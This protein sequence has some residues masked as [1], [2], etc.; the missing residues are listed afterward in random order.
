VGVREWAFGANGAIRVPIS[1]PFT[2][3]NGEALMRAACAGQGIVYSPRFMTAGAIADGRLVELDVGVPLLDLGAIYAIT[4]P[5]RRPAAR[6]RAHASQSPTGTDRR[7]R[8]SAPLA[9]A[10]RAARCWA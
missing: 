10:R 6:T 4:H 3:N 2:S 7:V 5:T 1:G 8:A 9:R